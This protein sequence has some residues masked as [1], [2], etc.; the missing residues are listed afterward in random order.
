MAN[1]LRSVAVG[2]TVVVV[3]N[4]VISQLHKRGYM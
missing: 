4:I 1:F 2:V 3:A